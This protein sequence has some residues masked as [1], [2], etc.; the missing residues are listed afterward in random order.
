MELDEVKEKKKILESELA[1]LIN[2]FTTETGLDITDI[3]V[4]ANRAPDP[5]AIGGG[6]RLISVDV[7]VKVEL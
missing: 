7:F 2:K 4:E 6:Y 5:Y 3:F 1:D